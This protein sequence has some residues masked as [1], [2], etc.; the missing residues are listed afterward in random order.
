MKIE[1]K[2]LVRMIDDNLIGIVVDV[3]YD[4]YGKPHFGVVWFDG[5]NR[6]CVY[7]EDYLK[8]MEFD[9]IPWFSM[10]Q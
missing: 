2:M 4:L 6:R 5:N 3:M 8:Y 1:E 9:E 10:I 7:T